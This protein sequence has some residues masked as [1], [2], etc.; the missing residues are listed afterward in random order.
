M[1]TAKIV[2]EPT[3]TFPPPPRPEEWAAPMPE[4]DPN[5][6]AERP[7][8]PDDAANHAPPLPGQGDAAGLA[9]RP[10]PRPARPVQPEVFASSSE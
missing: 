9:G 7:A 6:P 10:E 5:G 3:S 8:R 4:R 1:T 2:S